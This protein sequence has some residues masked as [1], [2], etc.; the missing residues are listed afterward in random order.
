MKMSKSGIT[1]TNQPEGRLFFE[2]GVD[3]VMGY[4]RQYVP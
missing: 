2:R 1:M 3:V 4:L